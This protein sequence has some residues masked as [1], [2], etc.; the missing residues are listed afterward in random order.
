MKVS[1]HCTSRDP[2][3][4]PAMPGKGLQRER[5][6]PPSSH[7]EATLKPSGSQP[8]GTLRP[9]GGYPEATLRLPPGYPEATLRLPWRRAPCQGR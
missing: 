4:L 2:A 3:G 9:P 6:K 1:G 5:A 8:V 7:P